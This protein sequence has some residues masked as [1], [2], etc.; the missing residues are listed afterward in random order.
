[1][2]EVAEVKSR[3]EITEVVGGYVPLKQAGRNLK[4]PCPFHQEKSASFMVSPEKGIYHCFGCGE[5]GDIFNFVMKM[6]GVNFREALEMLAR[7]AGVE[8]TAKKGENKEVNRLRDRLLRA[9]E[10]AVKYY[11]ASLVQNPKALEYVVS[12]R[13]LKKETV[14]AFEIGYAPDSWN[15][16]TDFLIKQGFS[17]QELLQ[18]GL[19]GQKDGRNTIYD[20]FRGRIMF[21]ITDREGR[22]VGFT[23]RVLDDSVPKYLNTPQTPLYDKST[24]I[25]GFALARESIR[26]LDEV[27]LV[28]GNMD[29]VASHQAGVLHVVA[30]SG[31]ALTLE[32]LRT[33]SK[34]TKNIKLAFDSDRAGL[35]ATERAIELGQKLGLTLR[36]VVLPEGYKDAD[37]LVQTD[38]ALWRKAIAEA[39]YI[40]DYLFERFQHD[41]DLNSAVGK[42]GYTDRLAASLRRLGDPVEQ[43]H[44]VKLL[45]EKTATSE[46]A[47]KAKLEKAPDSPIGAGGVERDRSGDLVRRAVIQ[48]TGKPTVRALHEES[49]LAL[50]LMY[51]TCR[52]SLD[53]LSAER[54]S[55]DDRRLIFELLMKYRDLPGAEI[56]DKTPEAAGYIMKLLLVS[57][58][59]NAEYEESKLQQEAFIVARKIFLESNKEFRDALSAAIAVAEKNG[60]EAERS[61]LMSKLGAIIDSER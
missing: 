17:T 31:T 56:A 60:N 21:T 61:A 1:M 48:V 25:F 15:A 42:R 36:M 35:A 51:P 46:E 59:E 30:A 53:D 12:K 57:E 7:K 19:A 40:V 24:A 33:L 23:G 55:T 11:Q 41:F 10:L 26:S 28:E 45:A 47:I 4:A 5:G 9:H 38:V 29:V 44:Y 16:L 32:Q 39:K 58:E 50:N 27:V 34:L 20:L 14:K 22:P 6:E 8:L 43:D 2:D 18:G 52:A 37:E 49:F 54:F 13:R 3:L